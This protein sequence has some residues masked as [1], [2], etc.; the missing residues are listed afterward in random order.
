[1]GPQDD[2]PI[3]SKPF[4]KKDMSTIATR[5]PCANAKLH[6]LLIVGCGAAVRVFYHLTYYPWWCG[7]SGG[8]SDTSWYWFHHQFSE[9]GRTP[10]YP[11]FLV[12]A[13]EVTGTQP[14]S[15][16][17]V[18]AA[19]FATVLQSLFGLVAACLVYDILRRLRVQPRIALVS[20]VV[21]AVLPG[22]CQF[23]MLILPESLSLFAIVV[24]VWLFVRT[25][26]GVLAGQKARGLAAITGFVFGLGILTRPE[27][28]IFAAVL[29]LFMVLV[30]VRLRFRTATS[31]LGSSLGKSVV[32][33]LLAALP[34]VL[35]WMSLSY[36]GIGEFRLTTLSGW[37][38][39]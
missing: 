30:L 23:E 12:L 28:L 26:N 37:V 36:V 27:N 1:V 2:T 31:A 8:Y 24:A 21:F 7:D 29:V 16:I 32:V 9:G 13:Q 14:M 5:T 4:S 11:L 34:V 38:A 35:T 10:V 20:A 6:L 22:V 25:I 19:H 17:S 33:V 3:A 18:A 15:R 39:S